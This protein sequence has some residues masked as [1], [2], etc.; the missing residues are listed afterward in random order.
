MVR[1]GAACDQ[2]GHEEDSPHQSPSAGD[3][4][5][6]ELLAA[7]AIDASD[8]DR[9]GDFSSIEGDLLYF[10]RTNFK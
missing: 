5:S 8:P 10:P 7:V 9:G 6:A 3:C 2:R 1:V 4:F